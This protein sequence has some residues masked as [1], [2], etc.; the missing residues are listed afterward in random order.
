[1]YSLILG[2][3]GDIKRI[4]TWFGR[5]PEQAIVDSLKP[6]KVDAVASS[7]V[8][9]LNN[10]YARKFSN[11]YKLLSEAEK[12]G[13]G[14][15]NAVSIEGY[16]CVEDYLNFLFSSRYLSFPITSVLKGAQD[17]VSRIVK[18]VQD[19]VKA[20]TIVSQQDG[21]SGVRDI[22]ILHVEGANTNNVVVMEDI[23]LESFRRADGSV[24]NIF[25][26]LIFSRVKADNVALL[27]S[28]SERFARSKDQALDLLIAY[29]AENE[30]YYA[31]FF[32]KKSDL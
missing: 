3:S 6:L 9:R 11:D 4:R 29:M 15:P 1:V 25:T 23:P 2:P 16:D 8:A 14:S 17:A 32:G 19:V 5:A 20:N 28:F 22:K 30:P 10:M 13:V 31:T 12:A 26:S 24:I 18:N 27:M 7:E 21:S